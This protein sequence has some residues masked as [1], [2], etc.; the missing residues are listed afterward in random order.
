MGLHE[1]NS[2]P[3]ATMYAAS[4]K[5]FVGKNQTVLLCEVVAM[6]HDLDADE[7]GGRSS[8]LITLGAWAAGGGGQQLEWVDEQILL[9]RHLQA[10]HCMEGIHLASIKFPPL[11][12]FDQRQACTW[13]NFAMLAK[14]CWLASSGCQK[15][16]VGHSCP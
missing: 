15:L 16:F 12:A 4:R 8:A 1:N 7:T 9:F 14:H 11:Q 10:C 13:L 6:L 3:S 5:S 2:K